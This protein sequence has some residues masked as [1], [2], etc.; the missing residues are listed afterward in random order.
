[1]RVYQGKELFILGVKCFG[2]V[3]EEKSAFSSFGQLCEGFLGIFAAETNWVKTEFVIR[4]CESL[5]K[6][7]RDLNFASC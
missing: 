7:W 4:D 1:M 6:E 2:V 3:Y 5:K